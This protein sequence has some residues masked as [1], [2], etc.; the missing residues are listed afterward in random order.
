MRNMPR[1]SQCKVLGR[2][3]LRGGVEL[4]EYILCE[5]EVQVCYSMTRRKLRYSTVQ[6][7]LSFH[8]TF[9]TV[10]PHLSRAVDLSFQ[11]TRLWM[12]P[13]PSLTRNS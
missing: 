3:T 4:T 5:G 9:G 7:H 12:I 11:S 2:R 8:S 1:R 6:G 10:A 13:D